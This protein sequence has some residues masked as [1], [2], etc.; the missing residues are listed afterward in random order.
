MGVQISILDRR[1][2][3]KYSICILKYLDLFCSGDPVKRNLKYLDTISTR[4]LEAKYQ[5][6]CLQR[7]CIYF[8]KLI[9]RRGLIKA[10][11]DLF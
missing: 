9:I 7:F 8:K 3:V 2:I 6:M 1:I 11:Q 10:C 4:F 5:D